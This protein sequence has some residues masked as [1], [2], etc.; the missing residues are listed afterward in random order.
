MRER[1]PVR[2]FELAVEVADERRVDAEEAAPGGK[3]TVVQ[4]LDVRY[5]HMQI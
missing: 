3:L 2:L 5:L 4:L 1:Q